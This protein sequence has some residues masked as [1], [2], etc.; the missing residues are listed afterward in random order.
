MVRDLTHFCVKEKK[1]PKRNK[2]HRKVNLSETS[3]KLKY[4]GCFIL[5]GNKPAS[6]FKHYTTRKERLT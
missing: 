2:M 1:Q 4:L 3:E 6:A 5:F